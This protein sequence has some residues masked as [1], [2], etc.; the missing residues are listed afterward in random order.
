VN[1]EIYVRKLGESLEI[2]LTLGQEIF[3]DRRDIM[4]REHDDR[5]TEKMGMY[6]TDT[7]GQC[8]AR[9]MDEEMAAEWVGPCKTWFHVKYV[10]IFSGELDVSARK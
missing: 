10:G 6:N 5:T 9:A 8:E 3:F 1:Q 2:L 7:C 4:H